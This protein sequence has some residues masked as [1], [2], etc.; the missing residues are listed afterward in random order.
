MWHGVVLSALSELEL[1]TC[2]ALRL[3]HLGSFLVALTL[4]SWL[5]MN[6]VSPLLLSCRLTPRAGVELDRVVVV[7]ALRDPTI[8]TI[9]PSCSRFMRTFTGLPRYRSPAT[10]STGDP[11]PFL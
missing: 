9:L 11:A 6:S 8:S 10:S 4:T 1:R 3:A 2:L 7:E 5:V